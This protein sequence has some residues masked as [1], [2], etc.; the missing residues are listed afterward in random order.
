MFNLVSLL[1]HNFMFLNGWLV[2][3]AQ[4]IAAIQNLTKE[5]KQRIPKTPKSEKTTKQLLGEFYSDKKYLENLLKDEGTFTFLLL[6]LYLHICSVS[7]LSLLFSVYVNPPAIMF[8][9]FN[10]LIF[11]VVI[12]W[13]ADL[14]KGKTKGGERLQDVIQNSLAYL[15]T[16]TEF[17]NQEQPICARDKDHKLKRQKCSKPRHSSSSEPAQFLLKSLQDIDAGKTGF[18]F[19]LKIGALFLA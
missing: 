6:Y 17:W 5:R 15:D 12:Q 10:T 19:N 13:S 8:F 3:R 16:C 4:P 9:T 1:T 7:T 11:K 14:V 18:R 2:K